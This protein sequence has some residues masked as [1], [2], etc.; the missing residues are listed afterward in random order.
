MCAA[1][2]RGRRD[3][4]LSVHAE[5][6]GPAARINAVH[7]IAVVVLLTWWTQ[8]V[9]FAQ[10][11]D[12][13][14][15]ELSPTVSQG[16]IHAVARADTQDFED[17]LARSAPP[18]SSVGLVWEN[19]LFAKTDRHYTNGVR[20]TLMLPPPRALSDAVGRGLGRSCDWGIV[21]GQQIFT[22]E[23]LTTEEPAAGDRPYAGWLYA[24]IVL[25]VRGGGAWDDGE[26]FPVLDMFELD[27]GFVGHGSLADATQRTIHALTGSELPRGWRTQICDGP[28]VQ[29]TW[30]RR[31]RVVQVLDLPISL[32]FHLIPHAGVT[33]GNV[34]NAARVGATVRFGWGLMGDFGGLEDDGIALPLAPRGAEPARSRPFGVWL[35]GRVDARFVAFDALLEGDPIGRVGPGRAA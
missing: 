15:M 17:E 34:V 18:T 14:G 19:D 16:P 31:V 10:D 2:R 28:G 9:A 12:P 8:G 24:G 30:L 23:D 29:V 35:V 33:V 5:G 25:R 26:R 6:A 13:I 27:V 20:L 3:E 4:R 22:P 11:L 32:E 1:A 7:T 21:A